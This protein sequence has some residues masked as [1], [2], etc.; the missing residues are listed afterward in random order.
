MLRWALALIFWALAQADDARVFLTTYVNDRRQDSSSQE[1]WN[2]SEALLVELPGTA[3]GQ[4]EMSMGY[5]LASANYHKLT[6]PP[7]DH[8]STCR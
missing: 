3:F 8:D 4:G 6:P 2:G 7:G 5:L 1:V